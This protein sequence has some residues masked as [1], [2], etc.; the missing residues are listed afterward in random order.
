MREQI[1]KI[2]QSVWSSINTNAGA[3]IVGAGVTYFFTRGSRE[4]ELVRDKADIALADKRIAGLEQSLRDS[5]HQNTLLLKGVLDR[6]NSESSVKLALEQC[7]RH[8]G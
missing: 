4:D 7:E 8:R 6:S 5:H 1:R 2:A 3:A